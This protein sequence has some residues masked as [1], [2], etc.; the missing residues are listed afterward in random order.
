MAE[1]TYT[2]ARTCQ[3][4]VETSGLA[5]VSDTTPVAREA[6]TRRRIMHKY[7][8]HA[9]TCSEAFHLVARIVALRVALKRCQSTQSF[10]SD[11]E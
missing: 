7:D 5:D 6:N 11:I 2:R 8:I 1:E 9:L 4:D 10:L 3:H